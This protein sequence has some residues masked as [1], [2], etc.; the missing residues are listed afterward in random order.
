MS[1]NLFHHWSEDMN[2]WCQPHVVSIIQG[3]DY[4]LKVN[5]A[6]YSSRERIVCREL[7]SKQSAGFIK[8]EKQSPHLSVNLQSELCRSE[9]TLTIDLT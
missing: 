7:I 1:D 2:D 4:E 5:V 3:H 9:L 6:L 8:N